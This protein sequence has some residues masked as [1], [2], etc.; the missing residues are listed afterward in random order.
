MHTENAGVDKVAIVKESLF[1]FITS[2]VPNADLSAIDDII[3]SYVYSAI[4]VAPADFFAHVNG[5]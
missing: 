1:N 5:K 4:E 3:L 2:H